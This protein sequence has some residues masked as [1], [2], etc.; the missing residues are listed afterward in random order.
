LT[1]AE[2]AGKEVLVFKHILVANDGSEM[3]DRAL[4]LALEYARDHGA[5]VTS[6]CVEEGPPAYLRQDRG[7]ADEERSFFE[8][9]QER[10][11]EAAA[12]FGV[13]IEA[14]ITRGRNAA[15]AIVATAKEG[16]FDLVVVGAKGH[17]RLDFLLGSTTDQV[18]DY[19]PCSVLIVR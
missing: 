9:V 1:G 5:R 3:A 12:S 16:S 6:L 7:R 18:S 4:A 11:R 8:G 17:A 15:K 13:A 19:A 2:R 14:P 10:A